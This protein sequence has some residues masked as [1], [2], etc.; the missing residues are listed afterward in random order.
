MSHV[1]YLPAFTLSS[2]SDL[3]LCLLPD[4][5]FATISLSQSLS[6]LNS[7]PELTLNSSFHSSSHISSSTNHMLLLGPT[8]ILT[9]KSL[10]SGQRNTPYNT[11]NKEEWQ[12]YTKSQP[13]FLTYVKTS[14]YIWCMQFT[15]YCV[16][17]KLRLKWSGPIP[18]AV[19]SRLVAGIVGSNPAQGMDVC[20]CVYMLC[21]PVQVEVSMMGWS[22]ESYRMSKYMCGHRNPKRGPVFQM[23]TTGKWM[24]EN[25]VDM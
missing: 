17:M 2:S 6:S 4:K 12:D 1:A 22:Q 15:W 5:N 18:V 24:N 11:Q 14:H 9:M 13:T 7:L 20:L 8:I 10:N 23:G 25:E 19:G 21:C 16:D 3:L